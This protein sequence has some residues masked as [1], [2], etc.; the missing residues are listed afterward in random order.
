MGASRGGVAYAGSTAPS[1]WFICDGSAI[2]R[3]TYS[4]LYTVIGTTYG[5]GDG[6]TTYNLPDCR[7]RVVVSLVHDA[8]M[9]L[10]ITGVPGT[11]K[12][13]V[14]DYLASEYGFVHL[15][16]ERGSAGHVF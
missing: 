16:F 7:G 10:L 9:R 14:G 6:A 12:T 15:D 13:T 4:D 11:G 2:S 1:G 3:T 8:C 5:S